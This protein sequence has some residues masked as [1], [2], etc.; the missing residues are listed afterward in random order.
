MHGHCDR[1]TL[2][3]AFARVILRSPCW[4][5]QK[6]PRKTLWISCLAAIRDGGFFEAGGV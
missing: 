3:R 1:F 4:L 6:I 2:L 5:V